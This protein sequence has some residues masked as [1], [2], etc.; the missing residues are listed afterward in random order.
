[1]D[2]KDLI[3]A[4]RGMT[5]MSLPLACLGCRHEHSCNVHGCA[6]IKEAVA[7]L[8]RITEPSNNPLTLDELREM[9]GDPVWIG[10]WRLWGLVSIS[11]EGIGTCGHGRFPFCLCKNNIYRRKPEEA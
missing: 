3:R 1:M 2:D 6:I 8:E 4:L 10:P 5:M 11:D 7:R 9:D